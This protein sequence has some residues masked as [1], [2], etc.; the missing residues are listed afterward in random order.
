[1]WKLLALSLAT[2]ALVVFHTPI[3][4]LAFFGVIVAVFIA[5]VFASTPNSGQRE[6]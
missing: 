4:A 6:V 5:A 3:A 2:V 1:M